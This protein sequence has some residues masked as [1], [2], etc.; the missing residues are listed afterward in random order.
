ME[1]GFA[2]KLIRRGEKILSAIPLRFPDNP[3]PPRF[4]MHSAGDCR[5]IPEEAIST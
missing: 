4:R 5:L 2:K 1:P 3:P